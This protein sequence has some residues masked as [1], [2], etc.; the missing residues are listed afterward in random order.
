MYDMYHG[1]V[2]I[3]IV[4]WNYYVCVNTIVLTKNTMV[5]RLKYSE[6]L[7]YLYHGSIMVAMPWEQLGVTYRSMRSRTHQGR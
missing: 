4:P 5:Y 6:M 7:R 2:Y 3:T 1:T